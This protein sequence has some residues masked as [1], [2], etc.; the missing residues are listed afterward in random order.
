MFNC[1]DKVRVVHQPEV[2]GVVLNP[3]DETNMTRLDGS[4]V[5]YYVRI[6]DQNKNIL[7][8]HKESLALINN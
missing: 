7:G 6:L 8:Y 2:F 5:G 4:K 1:L 3:R